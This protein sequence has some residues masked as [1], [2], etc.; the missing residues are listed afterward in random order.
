MRN[1][2]DD[3]EFLRYKRNFEKKRKLKGSRGVWKVKRKW[4]GDEEF[5]R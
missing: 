3:E 5:G 1:F 2:E 4:E